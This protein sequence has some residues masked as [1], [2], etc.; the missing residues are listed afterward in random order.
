MLFKVLIL[1]YVCVN[2]VFPDAV[3]DAVE[4]EAEGDVEGEDQ[5]ATE[6]RSEQTGLLFWL[7]I[8]VLMFCANIASNM[9]F[10]LFRSCSRR[11]LDLAMDGE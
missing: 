8:E 10:L 7:Q 4:A 6:L 1:I 11:R 2:W 5:S 9:V 3:E